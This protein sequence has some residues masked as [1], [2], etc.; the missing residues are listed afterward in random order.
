MT[1]R[2]CLGAK[3]TPTA[4]LI[5]PATFCAH[6]SASTARH[7]CAMNAGSPLRGDDADRDPPVLSC[8]TMKD[9]D[10]GRDQAGALLIGRRPWRPGRCF[11]LALAVIATVTAARARGVA[12]PDEVWASLMTAA[13][14]LVAWSSGAPVAQL[15]LR[16]SDARRGLTYG[17]GA[18]AVVLVVLVA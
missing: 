15:G 7:P 17:A 13:M 8:G 9:P 14:A 12:G 1:R 4:R 3:S 5:R 2:P 6:R 18:A 16:R 10:A 11:A